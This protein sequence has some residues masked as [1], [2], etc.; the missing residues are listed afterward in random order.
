MLDLKSFSQK[1]GLDWDVE[2]SSDDAP[3]LDTGDD[4]ELSCSYSNV[5]LIVGDE[6]A[7]AGTGTVHLTTR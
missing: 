1:F 7:T 4:E 5:D 2:L 6:G 3:I